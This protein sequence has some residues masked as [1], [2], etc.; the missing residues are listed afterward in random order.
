MKREKDKRDLVKIY[1]TPQT[2]YHL[3][4]MLA[5]SKSLRYPGQVVDK[6]IR[7]MAIED[8]YKER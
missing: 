2:A 4:R 7:T 6:I 3:N 5:Q 8:K 1:V